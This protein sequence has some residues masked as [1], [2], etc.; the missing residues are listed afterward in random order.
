MRRTAAEKTVSRCWR[1]HQVTHPRHVWEC[2]PSLVL[3]GYGCHDQ[4]FELLV[5]LF[6]TL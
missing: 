5:Q 1:E 6:D 2:E 3:K 4:L